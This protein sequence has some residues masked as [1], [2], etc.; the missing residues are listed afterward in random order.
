MRIL[1]R[2]LREK[3]RE[4]EREMKYVRRGRI[5]GSKRDKKKGLESENLRG[6]KRGQGRQNQRNIIG[7][8]KR[9]MKREKMREREKKMQEMMKLRKKS[10]VFRYVGKQLH[11]EVG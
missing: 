8:K 7:E 3:K 9:G 4:L 11:Q 10:H 6:L 1:N 5:I 2:V